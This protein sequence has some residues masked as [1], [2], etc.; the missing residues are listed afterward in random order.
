MTS[1][2]IGFW[3]R[4]L[5][6][7]YST[8]YEFPPLEWISNLLRWSLVSLYQ[9]CQYWTYLAWQ[10]IIVAYKINCYIDCWVFSSSSQHG[11]PCHSELDLGSRE[12]TCNSVPALFLYILHPRY[13]A[14]SATRSCHLVQEDND[15]VSVGAVFK[16]SGFFLTK[17]LY[18]GIPYL[19]LRFSFEYPWLLGLVLSTLV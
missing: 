17:S 11:S 9:P 16:A 18:R 2:V 1:L 14:F 3:L 4:F 13:V 7:D 12:G 10:I 6:F 15:K 19:I 5:Y 8:R